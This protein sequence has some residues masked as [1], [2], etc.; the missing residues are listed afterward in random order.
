MAKSNPRTRTHKHARKPKL[1][2]TLTIT[3]L[4][5]QYAEP[6]DWPIGFTRAECCRRPR[7]VP[8]IRLRGLWLEQAGFH[9]QDQINVEVSEGRLVITHR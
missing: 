8:F 6:K 3:G 5:Y 4:T 1:E 7:I 9:Y 2:R